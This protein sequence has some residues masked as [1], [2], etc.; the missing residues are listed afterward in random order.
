MTIIFLFNNFRNDVTDGAIRA[1]IC[2]EQYLIDE[3]ILRTVATL[4]YLL[5]EIFENL[6]GA[7]ISRDLGIALRQMLSHAAFLER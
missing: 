1:R 5:I 2:A 6:P 7:K 4:A 3:S